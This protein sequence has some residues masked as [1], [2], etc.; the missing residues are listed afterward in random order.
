MSSLWSR[1][2]AGDATRITPAGIL[3]GSGMGFAPWRGMDVAE[4]APRATPHETA[5]REGFAEGRAQALAEFEEQRQALATLAA[6]LS[7]CRADPP[8]ALA[9]VL[10][11]TVSR[12]VAQVVGEIQVSEALIRDRVETVARLIA[13]QGGPARMRLHPNDI[14]L[15]GNGTF[16]F[17][18]VPDPTLLS[19]EVIVETAS[20]WIEHGAEVGIERLRQA[21][22]QL[23][24][25]S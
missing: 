16:D 9:E 20:G 5:F 8:E 15:L 7:A 10:F 1:Q 25:L 21:L 11:E 12:L 23:S 14:A 2:S 4:P 19:G 13:E 3:P 6:N 24:V 22:D 17:A 18:L